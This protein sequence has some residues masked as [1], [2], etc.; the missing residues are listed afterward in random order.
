MKKIFLIAMFIA[1]TI[2]ATTITVAAQYNLDDDM[3]MYVPTQY[4]ANIYLATQPFDCGLGV[5]M[6]LI[7]DDVGFYFSMSYGQGNLYRASGIRDHVKQTLGLMFSPVADNDFYINIGF[8]HH[9]MDLKHADGYIL[10]SRIAKEYSFEL[11]VTRE[12]TNKFIVGLRTDILRWEPCVDF[13]M[14]F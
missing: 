9:S 13:G 8:N 1:T 6:E 10:D 5:R 12:I 11:G 7:Q 2:T 4:K 14:R 3:G